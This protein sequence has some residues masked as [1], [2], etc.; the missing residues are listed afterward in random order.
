MACADF[1]MDIQGA[2]EEQLQADSV[3]LLTKIYQASMM[4]Q[5]AK[6]PMHGLFQKP[7]SVLAVSN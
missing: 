2:D 3:E 1:D 6:G 4:V 7:T 5:C